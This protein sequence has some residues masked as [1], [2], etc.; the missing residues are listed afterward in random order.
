MDNFWAVVLPQ[1]VGIADT[2]KAAIALDRIQKEWVNDE[3]GFVHQ[4]KAKI[5]G[6]GVGVVHNKVLAQTAFA[7]GR[8]GLGWRL[9]QLSAKAPLGERMLGGFDETI[10]GG[11]DLVQLWSF[12]P[13][14]ECVVEGLAGVRPQPGTNR[15]DFFPQLPRGLEWFRLEDC[16]VGQHTLT[17]EHRTNVRS[18][19]TTVTHAR[20]VA[21]LTGT[22]WFPTDAGASVRINGRAIQTHSRRGSLNGIE[23]S[24]VDYEL[25]P[26]QA[27]TV[28]RDTP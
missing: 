12:G 4:W 7:Y 18:I 8:P 28:T 17:L 10:P 27:V 1:Q 23:R 26:G 21:P 14:L 20:G 3:W 13:F 25:R 15:V 22:F 11:G 6:E 2:D 9:M 16:R 5:T 19:T 24:A